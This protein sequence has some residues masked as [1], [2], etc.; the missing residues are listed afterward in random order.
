MCKRSI[1]QIFVFELKCLSFSEFDQR[2]SD[3]GEKKS[4]RLNEF[5]IYESRFTFRYGS[6]LF[7]KKLLVVHFWNWS[8]KNWKVWQKIISRIVEMAF[9][10]SI[11]FLKKIGKKGVSFIF[12]G[13]WTKNQILSK[14]F[15]LGKELSVRLAELPCNGLDLNFGAAFFDDS[16]S[17]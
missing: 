2:I 11:A 13:V 14:V 9:Y 12:S 7:E 5:S 15:L 6:F 8:L 10:V 3:R 4:D 1:G 16:Q 17:F